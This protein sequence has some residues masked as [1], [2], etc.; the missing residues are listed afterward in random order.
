MF[1]GLT[2]TFLLLAA[3]ISR[4]TTPDPPNAGFARGG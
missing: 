4:G 3:G 2:P 1:G